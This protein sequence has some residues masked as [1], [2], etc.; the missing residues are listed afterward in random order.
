MTKLFLPGK[1]GFNKHLTNTRLHRYMNFPL[2]S[3]SLL[4]YYKNVL[5]KHVLYIYIY[6]YTTI[7]SNNTIWL[8]I[9]WKII[10]FVPL[11]FYRHGPANNIISK[12]KFSLPVAYYARN[13]TFNV[14]WIMDWW[15][16]GHR[17]NAMSHLLIFLLPFTHYFLL[18]NI[19]SLC[20]VDRCDT[21]FK[22]TDARNV[23]IKQIA[24]IVGQ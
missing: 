2:R 20:K 6:I 15:I 4:L 12:K 18:N 7:L 14:M 22:M 3:N 23:Y 13:I 19:S 5:Y 11:C 1:S 9:F 21:L 24:V 10:F 17:I 8:N 16:S